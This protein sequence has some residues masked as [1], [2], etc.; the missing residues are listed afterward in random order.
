MRWHLLLP[1]TGVLAI[2]A[3]LVDFGR[4]I[5]LGSLF[6]EPSVAPLWSILVELVVVAIVVLTAGADVRSVPTTLRQVLASLILSVAI[7]LAMLHICWG[8]SLVKVPSGWE[9]TIGAAVFWIWALV[10]LIVRKPERYVL[11]SA[12]A[13]AMAIGTSLT[14]LSSPQNVDLACPSIALGIGG[15]LVW[16]KHANLRDIFVGGDC[17]TPMIDDRGNK[18]KEVLSHMTPT[19]RRDWRMI[20]DRDA[21][22]RLVGFALPISFVVSLAIITELDLSSKLPLRAAL[23]WRYAV[24]SVVLIF[25]VFVLNFVRLK[26]REKMFLASTQWAQEQG[27]TIHDF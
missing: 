10:N 25:V 2:G 7:A 3:L 19:E 1:V 27:H 21:W 8:V 20:C 14:A 13:T 17:I 18:R 5:V 24:A 23:S 22:W 4:S 6:H 9:L 15:L 16:A 11:L 26:K 12:G